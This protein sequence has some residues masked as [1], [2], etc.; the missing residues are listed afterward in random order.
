[1]ASHDDEFLARLDHDMRTLELR[2][3]SLA[4]DEERIRRERTDIRARLADLNRVATVYREYMGRPRPETNALDLNLGDATNGTAPVALT[5][6]VPDIAAALM[7][8]NGGRMKIRGILDEMVRI[9]KLKGKKGD[10][11]SVFGALARNKDRFYQVGPGEFGL[12]NPSAPEQP[13]EQ[14]QPVAQD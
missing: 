1:M 9:G 3:R 2:D 10:Y 5:G 14:S 13:A 11:G 7:A 4:E 8:A 12:R 6:T